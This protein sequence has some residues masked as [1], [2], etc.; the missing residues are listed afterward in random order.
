[1]RNALGLS[2]VALLLVAAPL[3][4]QERRRV[5]APRGDNPELRVHVAGSPRSAEL[6]T[7]ER[8][9]RERERL[10][11]TEQQVSQLEELRR[12]AL[13]RWIANT[14]EQEE[15]Q[16]RLRAGYDE[17]AAGERLGALADARRADAEETRERIDEILT[18][19][20]RET[21][22]RRSR[23]VVAPRG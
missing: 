16:S 17:D 21:L 20:Q 13:E 18:E 6:S 23:A 8:V 14:L 9:L 19:Q 10:E 2:V 1:M 12:Q 3:A 22:R 7:V 5:V 4:G 11:L 15:I